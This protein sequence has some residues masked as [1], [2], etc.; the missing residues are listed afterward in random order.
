MPV[1]GQNLFV[2]STGLRGEYRSG[3]WEFGVVRTGSLMIGGNPVVS[4]RGAA[5]ASPSGGATIDSAARSA[6]DLIL[7]ALRTHGLIDS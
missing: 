1:E 5:I 6:I 4:A 7:A 2:K 3:A